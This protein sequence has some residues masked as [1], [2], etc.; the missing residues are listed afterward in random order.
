MLYD[1]GDAAGPILAGLLV[2][3]LGYAQMFRVMATIAM[4]VAAVFYVFSRTPNA[5]GA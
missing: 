1:I 3:A 2:A 4:T 5:T